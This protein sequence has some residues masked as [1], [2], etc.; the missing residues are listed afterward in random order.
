L[1]LHNINVHLAFEIG[2]HLKIYIGTHFLK[3]NIIVSILFNFFGISLP[4]FSASFN[5]VVFIDNSF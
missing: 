2:Q 4:G 5:P 3:D 1:L